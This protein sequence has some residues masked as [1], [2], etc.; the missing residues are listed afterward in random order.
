MNDSSEA[1]VDP[2]ESAND[3][4]LLRLEGITKRYPGIVAVDD[5]SV[6]FWAGQV[7][8]LVG[9]N[10]AGKSSLI[11]VMA[12]AIHPDEGHM[13]LDGEPLQLHHPWQANQAGLAFVH[14][15]LHDVANL[16]VAENV[17]LGL[18]F[19]RRFGIFVDWAELDRRAVE[20][21]EQL[22][23]DLDP[24]EPVGELS[25]AKQRMVMIARGLA[26][27]ARMIV[28]DE[29]TASLS[30]EEIGHL[31][32]VVHKLRRSGIAV[33]YVS[34]RLEEIFAITER[35][36][37]MRNGSVVADLPTA[38]LDRASLIAY[39]TGHD[40]STTAAERRQIRQIGG[41]PDTEVVLAVDGIS[42]PTGVENCTFELHQ[43]EILGIAGLVGAG[44]TE[45][46]RAI[47]GAD[48]RSAGTITIGG[49]Q[50]SISNP[51][52]AIAAGMALLPEDRKT[53]GNVMDFSVRHNITLASL[54][55]HRVL[56]RLMV[57][58]PNSERARSTEL[59]D[60]LAIKTPHD[61][62]PVRLLSGGNQQK[63]VIAKWFAHGA[64]ILIFDEP[65]HGVDVDGKE[66]IYSV[67]EEL[68]ADGKSVIFISSEFSELVG[69]CNR[70]VVMQEG[71]IVGSLEGDEITE[72]A[73]VA[74]CYADRAKTDAS[75]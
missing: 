51:A 35:V 13:F 38:D 5:V 30:D 37:V 19:P 72:Q 64:D 22:D 9:K 47:F 57:P 16:S 1:M 25:V 69:L 26:Q 60:R 45:L 32:E 68:A 67:A 23:V 11:K 65:T 63:V 33:V 14:Q 39:I 7:V 74:M 28:L 34:H 12:S 46:V 52:D 2:A 31:F 54:P 62:Q 29:P 59:V 44:R 58:S 53:Q 3:V 66:E 71:Q 20:V 49:E 4:P 73:I 15:E 24:R 10:G 17:M 6:D 43:G 27:N 8:G 40:D 41:T 36:V 75:A 55:H 18:G 50:R 21:L 42:A 56:P 70:V 61:Q 48:P